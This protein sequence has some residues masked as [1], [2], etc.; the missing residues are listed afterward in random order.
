MQV[1]PLTG[2]LGAEVTGVD[3]A[4]DLSDAQV[5]ELR[6]AIC[7][8]QV[9]IVPGQRLDPDAQSRFTRRLGPPG[10][11]NFVDPIPGHPDVIL[12]L[13]TE[14]EADAFNFGGVWHSD[15][16]FMPEPPSFTVLHAID[17]PPYGGD[18]IWSSMV[19]AAALLDEDTRTALDGV[20]AVHTARDAYSPKMAAIHAGLK[21]MSVRTDESANEEH[22][23]PL[24]VRHP[25][26]GREVLFFNSAYVRDLD[27]TDDPAPLLRRLHTISTDVRITVRHHWRNGD[28]AIWDNRST[29][30]LALNDYPG[31]RRQLH[32]TTVGGT[33]PVASA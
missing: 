8:H 16:S 9:V 15:W 23:H 12:V 19:A 31:F 18:T 29:Q 22:R 2:V 25:E 30:H 24:L 26:T 28:V 7:A 1:V 13:K 17:V 3:L 27:G 4:D 11:T 33:A 10:P 14:D 6:A 32:R 20:T 21:H 5:A